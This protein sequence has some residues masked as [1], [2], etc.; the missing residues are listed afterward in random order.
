MHVHG[1]S[2][3]ELIRTR[4][5][6]HSILDPDLLLFSSPNFEPDLAVPFG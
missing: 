4:S 6:F 1:L 2:G 3:F 5:H